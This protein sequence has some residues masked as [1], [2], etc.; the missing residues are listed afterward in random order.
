V[1]EN[2]LGE[3][4]DH[5]KFSAAAYEYPTVSE[6]AARKETSYLVDEAPQNRLRLS[7]SYAW[8]S[9]WIYDWRTPGSPNEKTVFAYFDCRGLTDVHSGRVKG[10]IQEPLSWCAAATGLSVDTVRK[11]LRFWSTDTWTE[12]VHCPACVAPSGMRA[13]ELRLGPDKRALRDRR[14]RVRRFIR[15]PRPDCAICSGK[16]KVETKRTGLG[17]LQLV[18]KKPRE[19]RPSEGPGPAWVQDPMEII[20]LPGRLFDRRKQQEEIDRVIAA[21]RRHVNAR[22]QDEALRIHYE[23]MQEWMGTE[24][25]IETFWR[26]CK[27]RW[28]AAGIPESEIRSL[29]GVS[30][31]T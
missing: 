4:V 16:G 23:V 10:V 30:P 28:A 31:P 6:L 3:T 14:G 1:Y 18:P 8:M 7:K 12:I 17:I 9:G 19:R 13:W 2:A 27:R 29:I 5:K 26:E 11:A 25:K 24:R 15:Q 22:W 21:A 20:F